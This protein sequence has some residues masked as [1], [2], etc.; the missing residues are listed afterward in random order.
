MAVLL[1]QRQ[2]LYEVCADLTLDTDHL[3][4]AAVAARILEH[5]RGSARLVPPSETP[6]G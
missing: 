2:P 1:A 6:S 5:W 3:E 4:P